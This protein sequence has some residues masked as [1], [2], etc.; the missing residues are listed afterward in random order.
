MTIMYTF[1]DVNSF[2]FCIAMIRTEGK[3]SRLLTL[4][5]SKLVQVIHLNSLS[6]IMKP[7]IVIINI[8]KMQFTDILYDLNRPFLSWT[9]IHF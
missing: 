9:K 7:V 8:L 5:L 1:Y 6:R 3:E 2:F 4:R